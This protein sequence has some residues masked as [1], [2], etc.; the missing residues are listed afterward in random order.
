MA[1]IKVRWRVAELANVMTQFDTQK[2]YRSTT[3]PTGSFSEITDVGTRVDLVASEDEYYFDDTAGSSAYYYA[4]S[5]YN[6]STTAE[7]SLSDAIKGDTIGGVQYLGISDLENIV[8]SQRVRQYFDDDMDESILDETSSTTAILA[9][10]E[11]EA[12]SRLLR[13][14]TNDQIVDMATHDRTM[15]SHVAWIALEFAYERRP[16]FVTDQGHGAYWA[17]YERAIEFFEAM[18]KGNLRS[19]AEEVIGQNAQIGGTVQPP[20]TSASDARFTFA[21]D[22]AAPKGKGGF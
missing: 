13:A 2:I 4:V 5:Y 6:T 18:A 17:Q 3:G 10:A 9:A 12:A 16:E 11:A 22:V 15:R 7:S 14:Y 1:I 8:G 19:T 21:P 20:R